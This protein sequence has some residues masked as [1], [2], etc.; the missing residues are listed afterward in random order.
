MFLCLW[1]CRL[2][3]FH[4]CKASRRSSKFCQPV[5]DL[6][7]SSFFLPCPPSTT[8]H[9]LS[10]PFF[11]FVFFLLGSYRPH[12]FLAALARTFLSYLPIYRSPK[13]GRKEAGKAGGGPTCR[14]IFLLSLLLQ[15]FL[16]HLSSFLLFAHDFLRVRATRADSFARDGSPLFSEH[17]TDTSLITSGLD[18]CGCLRRA[19]GRDTG[20]VT[21][22]FW[23]ASREF[24]TSAVSS[25][26]S[27]P[28]RTTLY[29]AIRQVMLSVINVQTLIER[30][31]NNSAVLD[32]I[33]FIL[34]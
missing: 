13:I 1:R 7:L 18:S 16:L 32:V 29:F 33:R 31:L 28:F 25:S 14:R 8:P 6:H 23:Q 34:Q 2:V 17:P 30:S 11:L 19:P 9:L 27:H 15:H 26:S 22:R 12:V 3:S 5:A 10:F 21:S 24:Q 20:T 4:I